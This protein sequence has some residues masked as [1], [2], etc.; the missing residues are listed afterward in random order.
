MASK[1]DGDIHQCNIKVSLVP[2]IY[3]G[4]AILKRDGL[5]K[6]VYSILFDETS[7]LYELLKSALDVEQIEV[8]D[9]S[10]YQKEYFIIEIKCKPVHRQKLVLFLN[11][12]CFEEVLL[13]FGKTL[14]KILRWNKTHQIQFKVLAI[15]ER[16][17]QSSSSNE[18][19]EDTKQVRP[20]PERYTQGPTQTKDT[21]IE[22]QGEFGKM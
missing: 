17:P 6:K 20:D 2:V 16:D 5:K 8:T 19:K 7:K 9:I 21:P 14:A 18:E 10:F 4:V 1:D 15:D 3:Q 22:Q 13:S 12:F 11:S